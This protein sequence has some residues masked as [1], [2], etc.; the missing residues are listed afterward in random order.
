MSLIKWPIDPIEF[1]IHQ[2]NSYAGPKIMDLSDSMSSA[3]TLSPSPSQTKNGARR[4]RPRLTEDA[5]LAKLVLSLGYN[6]INWVKKRRAQLRD[7]QRGLRER[8]NRRLEELQARVAELERENSTLKS[9]HA[10]WIIMTN[11]S[12][13]NVEFLTTFTYPS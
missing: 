2:H 1:Q 11:F 8:K 9:N 7:A 10:V 3:S 6:E 5:E 12:T 4:G 13:D